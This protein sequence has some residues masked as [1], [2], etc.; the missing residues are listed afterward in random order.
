LLL[1]LL[2]TLGAGLPVLAACDDTKYR[3][4]IVTY[5]ELDEQVQ[6]YGDTRCRYYTGP[7]GGLRCKIRLRGTLYYPLAS[8]YDHPVGQPAPD[9]PAI[10]IN[11]G[12]EQTF[13][14]DNKFCDHAEYFVPK[15]YIVFVPFRRGH[16]DDD[17]GEGNMSTGV[18]I[19]DL[20]DDFVNGTN[21]YVHNTNCTN[22]SCYKAE[23]LKEQADEEIAQAMD[24]L[25]RRNDVKTD[26]GE[27]RDYRIAIMGISYGGA[28]TVFANRHDLGQKAAVAFSPGAQQWDPSVNCIPGDPNCGTRFSEIADLGRRWG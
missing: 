17:Q 8:A 28:V 25:E 14:A 6:G 18:Y 5:K 3:T 27:P 7:R 1:L 10:L 2:A 13:E 4:Q 26:P 19:E 20:L 21:N 24:W 9:F 12:S 22:R 16:G 23:L 15:G 11:H